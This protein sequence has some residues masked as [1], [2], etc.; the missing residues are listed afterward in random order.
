MKKLTWPC[1]RSPFADARVLGYGLL[2][3]LI[4][5]CQVHQSAGRDEGDANASEVRS[6][7]GGSERVTLGPDWR[8]ASYP[9]RLVTRGDTP[10]SSRMAVA[11]LLAEGCGASERTPLH[12][13]VK[14]NSYFG[15]HLLR[16][17][18]AGAPEDPLVK[19]SQP[20]GPTASLQ[21]LTPPRDEIEAEADG[22]LMRLAPG[23]SLY[24]P[25]KTLACAQKGDI[26]IEP[27]LVTQ[28]HDMI[29]RIAPDCEAV[30][31]SLSGFECRLPLADPE[32]A[33]KE[34]EEIRMA[35]I[36][37]WSRQPYLLARRLAVALRLAE[38]L[39][40]AQGERALQTFCKVARHSL[41]IEL[42][43]TLASARWQTSVCSGDN[44]LASRRNAAAFG[45]AKALAEVDFLRQLF[46]RTSKLGSLTLKLPDASVPGEQIWVSL[47]PEPDVSERL[48]K[49]TA[50]LWLTDADKSAAVAAD[51]PGSC[52]HP[53]YGESPK[54]IMLARHLTL[55]GDAKQIE[56][57]SGKGDSADAAALA[58]YVTDSI[59]SETEFLMPNK[60]SKT[61]RLPVGSYRYELRGMPADPS[62]WD[63]AAQAETRT[64]GRIVWDEKRPRPVIAVW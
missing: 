35:M 34:L 52:W 14:L 47:R 62:E 64:A 60:R 31:P 18:V 7:P 53:V 1:K 27:R 23:D 28:L 11:D 42:P 17:S 36:R 46:E 63:D 22:R 43:A 45:L 41:P 10:G 20:I 32:Q 16:V 26:E 39:Q 19:A 57:A 50:R 5:A 9:S 3:S 44:D 15:Q 55:A 4:V 37:R 6:A 38:A 56:C 40:A 49:E 51:L 12:L 2:A 25:L 48:A 21:A 33:K 13:R 30:E 8:T 59:T 24:V 58:R 54:L 61:L 29:T